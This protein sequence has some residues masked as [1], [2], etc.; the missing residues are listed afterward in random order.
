MSGA[1]AYAVHDVAPTITKL[2]AKEKRG[3]ALYAANCA[4]CHAADGTG[5]N[6]IGRFMEPPARDLTSFSAATM[7]RPQLIS[8]IRDGLTGTSM[9]AWK[10]VLRGDEIDPIAAYASRAFFRTDAGSAI[11]SDVNRAQRNPR[12]ASGHVPAAAQLSPPPAWS[13]ADLPQSR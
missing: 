1:S 8:T 5:K 7:P 2:S 9:P 13:P 3:E 6:W 12:V 10:E 11:R 4:F